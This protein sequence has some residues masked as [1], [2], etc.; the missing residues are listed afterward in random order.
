M[1]IYTCTDHDSHWVGGASV[2]VAEDEAQARALLIAELAT[3]GLT[4]TK[5]FTLRRINADVA[6]AFVLRDGDY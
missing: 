5:S 3:H 2:V 4:G 6:K 1:N